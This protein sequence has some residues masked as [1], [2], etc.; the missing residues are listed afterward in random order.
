MCS[1]D[2]VGE[3]FLGWND[4]KFSFKTKETLFYFS[5]N[6]NGGQNLG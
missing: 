3:I 1:K 6:H 2:I 4:L 5:D